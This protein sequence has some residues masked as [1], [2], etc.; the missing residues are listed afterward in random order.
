MKDGKFMEDR[1][2]QKKAKTAGSD[3]EGESRTEGK[4]E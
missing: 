1:S 2:L 3:P 4:D